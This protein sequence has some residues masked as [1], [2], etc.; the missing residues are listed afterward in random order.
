MATIQ[1][2]FDR[3]AL[4]S[5]EGSNHNE[6]YHSFLLRQVPVACREAWRQHGEHDRYLTLAQVR[7]VCARV[8]P[9]THVRRH[10]LWRYSIVWRK[11]A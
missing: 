10:L 4:L 5:D 2:D 6:H 7:Q 9:G 8:L 1:A 3:L 11:P